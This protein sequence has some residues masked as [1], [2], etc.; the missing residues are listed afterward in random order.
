MEALSGLA[1]CAF[2]H[3]AWAF[4]LI[5]DDGF[6]FKATGLGHPLIPDSGRIV[7]D[8]MVAAA[9]S[10]DVLTG[11]NMAGKSTF[12]RTI[13]VNA[14][15]AFA[16]GPVCAR[17]LEISPF[18]L[19][20]SMKSSDSLD[21][22]MSLFYAE[23]L[24]LKLIL[25]ETRE[26]RPSFFL[27]DEM[28]RGTNALD[29]HKGSLAMIRRLLKEGATGIVATHD[30]GLTAL[31]REDPR[32]VNHHFDS[33]IEDGTLVFDFKIKPGVCE[34]FNALILMKKIGLDV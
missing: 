22:H 14:V 16:G 21:K 27:I 7:N 13:G 19:I 11:P 8:Y 33:A 28:L 30:L 25:D 6:C 9:G 24:R 31:A 5:R 12:L 32:I 20:T 17:S 2:N 23:L 3:P 1:N 18:G 34:S 26:G 10:I 4:P 29:R 15:L